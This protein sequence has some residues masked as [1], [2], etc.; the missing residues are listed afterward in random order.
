MI[1]R[2][3]SPTD[4]FADDVRDGVDLTAG[5]GRSDLYRA[6]YAV[7][8][9]LLLAEQLVPAVRPALDQFGHAERQRPHKVVTRRPVPVPKLYR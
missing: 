4:R 6:G 7:E 2:M 1:L 9:A 5:Q 3:L 8:L